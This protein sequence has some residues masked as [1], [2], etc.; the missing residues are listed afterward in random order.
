MLDGHRRP[1]LLI[2]C[3][4]GAL[5]F[6]LGITFAALAGAASS[7][8]LRV[9][10]RLAA[11]ILSAVVFLV[12]L[13][14]ERAWQDNKS[15][16]ITAWHLALAVALGAFALA[17]AASLRNGRVLGLALLLWPLLLGAPAFLAALVLAAL[18]QIATRTKAPYDNR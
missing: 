17:L 16:R 7:Q 18:L 10:W 14:S 9:T 3:V 13:W 15:P 4:A 11:W 2:A 6:G 1:W 5:Y 8:Q 12:H